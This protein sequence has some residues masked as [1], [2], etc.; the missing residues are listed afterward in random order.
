MVITSEM[1]PPG[2]GKF[3]NNRVFQAREGNDAGNA[4]KGV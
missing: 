4:D 1:L 3:H 2:K